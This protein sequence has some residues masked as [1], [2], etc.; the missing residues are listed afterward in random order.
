VGEG[1]RL[2]AATRIGRGVTIGANAVVAP[3]V[4]VGR[5]VVI[6][7][8]AVVAGPVPPNAIVRGNPGVITGYVADEPQPSGRV[9]APAEPGNGPTPTR[10][11]GVAIHRLTRAADLRGS[12]TAMN[13]RDLPFT[14]MRIFTVFDVPSES[15]R[16]SHAHRTCELF[17]VCLSGDLNCVIDDGTQRDEV[18]LAEPDRGLHLPPLV[19]GTQYKYSRDAVLLVLA[20]HPYDPDDYIRDYDE[21][22]EAVGQG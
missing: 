7:P 4:T 8:G 16:G 13:F 10:V 22:L 20:S 21:F 15:I 11:P 12:L 2:L 5:G 19:W 14:P 6:E 17:L 9:V 1:A 3:G 18:R